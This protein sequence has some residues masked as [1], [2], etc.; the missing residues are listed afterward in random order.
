MMLLEIRLLTPSP[1]AKRSNT[2]RTRTVP[3]HARTTDPIHPACGATGTL[4]LPAF[5]PAISW[6]EMPAAPTSPSRRHDLL[7]GD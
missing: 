7:I 3:E 4:P 6:V 1:T 2:L 5:R